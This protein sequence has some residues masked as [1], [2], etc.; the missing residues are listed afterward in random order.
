MQIFLYLS[1]TRQ[2]IKILGYRQWRHEI[3]PDKA[4][5]TFHFALVVS[6]SRPPKAITKKIMCKSC[7][8]ARVWSLRLCKARAGTRCRVALLFFLHCEGSLI[9][10]VSGPSVA[11]YA[12]NQDQLWTAST[13][14][15]NKSCRPN[16]LILRE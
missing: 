7:D 10:I 5:Q 2:R 3:A 8:L 11:L 6:L 1:A 4:D 13:S 12:R 15:A 16:A 9:L 14:N